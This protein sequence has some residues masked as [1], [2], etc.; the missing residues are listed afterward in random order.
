MASMRATRAIALAT[1]LGLAL[2][3]SC[4]YPVEDLIEPAPEQPGA[5]G[6]GGGLVVTPNENTG[7]RDGERCVPATNVVVLTDRAEFCS[8]L[9]LKW[10]EP[11]SCECDT[12]GGNKKKAQ[13]TEQLSRADGECHE[14]V[15][16][17]NISCTP[18]QP[19]VFAS[20]RSIVTA[21]HNVNCTIRKGVPVLDA[22]E[23]CRVEPRRCEGDPNSVCVSQSE[24]LLLPSDH[25]VSCPAGYRSRPVFEPQESVKDPKCSCDCE[26]CSAAEY[27]LYSE[28][29][30]T[31][32]WPML[33][34]ADRECRNLPRTATHYRQLGYRMCKPFADMPGANRT[35]CTPVGAG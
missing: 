33:I 13:C 18:M 34:E 25:G 12:S 28:E 2:S 3:Q 31:D 35:L 21:Q 14:Y 11:G 9:T 16:A 22:R 4:Y 27:L 8:P 29:N 20:A 5:S 30:C 15:G 32:P 23:Y 10:C 7:C 17:N 6:A 1:V 24:Y 19:R 26:K